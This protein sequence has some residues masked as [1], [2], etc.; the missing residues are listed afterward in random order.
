MLIIEGYY[1]VLCPSLHWMTKQPK[2][3]LFLDEEKVEDFVKEKRD[4]G[5]KYD[6]IK[7]Y[8]LKHGDKVFKLEE[9]KVVD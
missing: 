2:F 6:I 3:V 1:A 5:V 4:R 8:C 9:V 7:G